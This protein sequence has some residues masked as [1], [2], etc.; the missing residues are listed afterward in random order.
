MEAM[1]NN[2]TLTKEAIMRDT[3]DWKAKNILA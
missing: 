3:I 1:A 2:R